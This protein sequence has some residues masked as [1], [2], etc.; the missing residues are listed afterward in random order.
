M[1]GYRTPLKGWRNKA[2]PFKSRGFSLSRHDALTVFGA[3]FG[4]LEI[5]YVEEMP[6]ALTYAGRDYR[7]GHFTRHFR[8]VCDYLRQ[9]C[10]IVDEVE[11]D[12][13]IKRFALQ[14]LMKDLDNN[15]T[16]AL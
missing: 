2:L 3:T 4:G 9:D 5:I 14:E 13:L 8:Q 16:G 12:G 7:L 10:V 15:I 11:L 6:V 1:K